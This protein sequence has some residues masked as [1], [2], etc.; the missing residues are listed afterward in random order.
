[1]REGR[2]DLLCGAV[3]KIEVDRNGRIGRSGGI[4][5]GVVVK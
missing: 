5:R 1:L 3:V 2:G 4:L